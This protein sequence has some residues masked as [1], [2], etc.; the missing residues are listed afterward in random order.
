MT[1]TPRRV[2]DPAPARGPP[3]APGADDAAVLGAHGAG[4]GEVEAR[5]IA[6]TRAGRAHYDEL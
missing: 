3:R 5:G 1:S 4:F 2:R 6:L